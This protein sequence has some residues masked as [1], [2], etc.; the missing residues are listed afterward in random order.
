MPELPEVVIPAGVVELGPMG[1]LWWSRCERGEMEGC[2][3]LAEAFVMRRDPLALE[4][5][6]NFD[7]TPLYLRLCDAQWVEGCEDLGDVL[8]VGE[9]K[10]AFVAY[11]EACGLNSR[12]G[13]REA[14]RLIEQGEVA[15]RDPWLA[16]RYLER[17]CAYGDGTACWELVALVEAGEFESRI[18]PSLFQIY[19]R[20]CHL[21]V[22]LA[23]YREG[24]ALAE[25]DGVEADE[26]LAS[27]RFESACSP[28]LS[29]ACFRY[30]AWLEREPFATRDTRGAARYFELACDHGVQ[31]A[32]PRAEKMQAEV[33]EKIRRGI[34]RP[35]LQLPDV[36]ALR[37]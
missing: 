24:L 34:Y 9:P 13:C 31:Q 16:G 32:C 28:K 15:A 36:C 6:P 17:A 25:G 19:A 8:R 5:D 10:R 14:G 22:A 27:L 33:R 20:G 26:A 7:P 3:K 37:W 30:G 18:Y 4:L 29:D 11:D 35:K 23:C 1:Q 2:A 12:H 21:G